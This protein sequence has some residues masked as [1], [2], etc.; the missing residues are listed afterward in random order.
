MIPVRLLRI[1]LLKDLVDLEQIGLQRMSAA[2]ST[3]DIDI[4]RTRHLVKKRQSSQI[5]FKTRNEGHVPQ[6][7]GIDLYPWS[8]GDV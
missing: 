6:R 8:L 4:T 3:A 2:R 5:Q 1:Q 7:S